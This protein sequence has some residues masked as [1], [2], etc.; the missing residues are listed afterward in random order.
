MGEERTPG[1][2]AE[3]RFER[4]AGRGAEKDLLERYAR[5]GELD[6]AGG[7]VKGDGVFDG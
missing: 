5:L 6:V 2:V 7:E 4:I 3:I 1:R